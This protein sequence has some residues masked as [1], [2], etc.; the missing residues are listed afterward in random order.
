[1]LKFPN[2]YLLVA[3]LLALINTVVVFLMFGF[4][5]FGDSDSY[6]YLIDW[7]LGK[8]NQIIVEGS[9]NISIYILRPLIALL[10]AP[11][12]GLSRGSGIIIQNVMFYFL[13][14][15]LIFRITDLIY[16]N[17]EQAL[18]AS[19]LYAFAIPWLNVGLGYMTNAGAWFFVIFS[20]YL[21]LLYFKKPSKKLLIL[22]GLISGMGI[23]MKESGGLGIIFFAAVLLLSKNLSFSEKFSKMLKFGVF[24]LIAPVIWEI[25]ILIFFPPFSHVYMFLF[26]KRE[27]IEG[28]SKILILVTLKQ[29]TAFL[30]TFGLLGWSLILFGGWKEW[31]EK[32]PERARIIL[33]FVIFSLIFLAWWAIGDARHALT[34]LGPL[35]LLGSYGLVH[36]KNAFRNKALGTASMISIMC[37]YVFLNHYS[38]F[39]DDAVPLIDLN[40]IYHF[41]IKL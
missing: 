22:G 13:A 6:I 9:T 33:A 27:I 32:N 14:T 26:L 17:K 30:A 31:K 10:A 28:A 7:F 37:L 5:K 18:L 38:N 35:V 12:Q 3:L 40:D 21:I 8:E 39:V 4:R 19:I 24:F 15:Y 36:L 16:R 23:L 11:F 41:L 1:M 25:V 20:V 2:K 29:A 34:T